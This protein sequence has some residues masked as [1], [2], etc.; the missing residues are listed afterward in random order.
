[1]PKLDTQNRMVVAA[2][3]GIPGQAVVDIQHLFVADSLAVEGIQDYS[4]VDNQDFVAEDSLVEMD[5]R[6]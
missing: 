1:M 3:V 5:N 4:V 2:V 6:R